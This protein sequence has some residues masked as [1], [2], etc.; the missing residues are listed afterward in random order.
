MRGAVSGSSSGKVSSVYR[1]ATVALP[2]ESRSPGGF[3][4]AEGHSKG[5]RKEN[6]LDTFLS[7]LKF[8]AVVYLL[9]TVGAA[10]WVYKGTEDSPFDGYGRESNLSRAT[11]AVVVGL[12]WP[13]AALIVLIARWN[14]W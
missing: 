1:F 3:G 13:L 7:I 10:V 4:F 5:N 12:L 11:G 6:D 8:V 9:I 14:R 2:G